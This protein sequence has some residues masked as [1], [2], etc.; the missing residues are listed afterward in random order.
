MAEKAKEDGRGK[1]KEEDCMSWICGEEAKAKEEIG[2][3][4]RIKEI[5]MITGYED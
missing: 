2:A 4:G 3:S 1:E 5:G